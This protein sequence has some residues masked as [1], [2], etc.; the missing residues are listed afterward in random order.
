MNSFSA[1]LLGGVA[2]SIVGG[3]I[4]FLIGGSISFLTGASESFLAGGFDKSV[5]VVALIGAYIGYSRPGVLDSE[6]GEE[7]GTNQS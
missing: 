2:G 5:F 6:S 4:A 3:S 7:G 1:N